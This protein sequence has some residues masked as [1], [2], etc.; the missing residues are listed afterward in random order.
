MK[1]KKMII[2][3]MLT[4]AFV[5]GSLGSTMEVQAGCTNFTEYAADTSFCDNTDG[6]GFLWLQNTKKHLSYQHR[7]CDIDGKQ[8]YQ[9]RKLY[10]VDGCC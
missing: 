9:Q 7:F 10:V 6:C 1:L 8:Y 3:T 5:V 4:S 2:A